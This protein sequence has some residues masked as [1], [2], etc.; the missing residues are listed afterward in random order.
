MAYWNTEDPAV[1]LIGGR[2]ICV[3]KKGREQAVQ[4]EKLNRW[5]KEHIAPVSDQMGGDQ[6]QAGMNIFTSMLGQLTADGQM[7]LATAVLGNKDVDGNTLGLMIG[8]R[9]H[10]GNLV[11]EE[12]FLD[13]HY[14]IQWLIEAVEVANQGSAVQRLLTAF[15]TNAG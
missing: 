11:G 1:F 10:E 12:G 4:I 6:A 7:E 9:D 3:T 13:K 2:K 5:L 14:D 15:F 8:K